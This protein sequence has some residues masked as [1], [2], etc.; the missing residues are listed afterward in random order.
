TISAFRMP[1]TYDTLS[2]LLVGKPKARYELNTNSVISGEPRLFSEEEELDMALT[3]LEYR[4]LV[5][6]DRRANRYDLHPIVRRVVWSR[7]SYDMRREVY[8]GLESYFEP[9]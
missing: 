1:T 2:A 6:W 8:A 5:G 7:L 3:E 9:L 4:G